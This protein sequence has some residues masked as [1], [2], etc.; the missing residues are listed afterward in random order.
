MTHCPDRIELPLR[1]LVICYRYLCG[2]SGSKAYILVVFGSD[3]LKKAKA[4]V[5]GIAT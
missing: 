1:T 3:T 4:Q 2:A 5:L